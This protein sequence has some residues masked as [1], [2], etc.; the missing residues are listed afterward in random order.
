[1]T[2]RMEMQHY[3]SLQN[4]YSFFYKATMS[5]EQGLVTRETKQNFGK[6]ACLYVLLLAE[7]F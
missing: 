6:D 2:S 7:Y 3:C 5:E 1:M 4:I